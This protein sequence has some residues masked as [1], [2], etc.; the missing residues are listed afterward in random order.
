MSLLQNIVSFIGL[1]CK[2]DLQFYVMGQWANEWRPHFFRVTCINKS[3]HTREWCVCLSVWVHCV[4][5]CVCLHM[6]VQQV[7]KYQL[8]VHQIYNVCLRVRT[9]EYV[10]V[11]VRVRV[12]MCVRVCVCVCV[13][14]FDRCRSI[15]CRCCNPS[16]H[17]QSC[18]FYLTSELCY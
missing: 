17:I 7:Q 6:R 10:F 8:L 4:C 2:R 16:A 15:R 1:F 11:S 18:F 3:C 13:C 9:S 12:C 14:V 5:V